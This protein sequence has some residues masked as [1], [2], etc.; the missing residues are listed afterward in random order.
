MDLVDSRG[1]MKESQI[2]GKLLVLK[3]IIT[4]EVLEQANA[5]VALPQET[6]AIDVILVQ[7]FNVDRDKVYTEISKLYAIPKL[8]IIADKLSIEE[9]NQI[10]EFLDQIPKDLKDEALDKGIIPYKIQK[11]RIETLLI[12]AANPIDTLPRTIAEKLKAKRHEVA[13]CPWDQVMAIVD[14]IKTDENEYLKN[15]EEQED[16][17]DINAIEESKSEDSDDLLDQEINKGA[18]VYLF[19]AALVEAVKLK[20]SDVHIIPSGNTAIEIFFRQDGKLQLWKRKEPVNPA[21]FQAVVKDRSSEVDR[22]KVD[23]AQDGFIQREIDGTTIRFR[24]SILPI[25][26][27]QHDKHYESIVIRILDDRN[28]ITDIDKLGFLPQARADFEKAVSK[29]Q[30]LIIVTGPT[31]SGKSTTLIGALY[32]VTNPEKNVLTVEQPVEYVIKG[33]RQIKIS[34]KLDFQDAIRAIL[35]HD[36]DIVLVGEIRDKQT[37]EI[38]IKLANTGHLTLST[39][40]TND[41]PSAVSRLY[42]MGVETFLI[43]YAINVI[44]AQRLVRRLCS[45]KKVVDPK[46]IEAYKQNGIDGQLIEDGHVFEANGCEICRGTGYKGRAAIHE[47]LY[48]TKEIREEIV[49]SKSDIDEDRIRVLARKNGMLTLRDSGLELVRNGVT[50]LEEVIATTTTD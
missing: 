9:I 7:D 44:V 39:L 33:A 41:A 12:L 43:A 34:H 46:N 35:R 10:K 4:S 20:I 30:G 36:P 14:S 21:A 6:R 25:V 42:K 5:Q 19:E 8:N 28:V 13:Y 49:N 26:S 48:F 16:Q 27:V 24:V 47:A 22:F 11:K 32:H 37:A 17:I 38:G 50:S 45:C 3:N 31:G 18:L 23:E 2:F 1:F 15:L 40:H 29:P